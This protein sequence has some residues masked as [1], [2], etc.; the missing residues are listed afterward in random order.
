LTASAVAATFAA[1]GSNATIA[2]GLSHALVTSLAWLLVSHAYSTAN[3][4]NGGSVIYA[5]NGS[6]SHPSSGSGGGEG[7]VV[8]VVIRDVAVAGAVCTA[9][10][11]IMLES[12]SFGGLAYWGLF[13]RVLGEQWQLWDGV[14]SVA[15]GAG[16]VGVH[17]V[18]SGV[19]LLLVS[20]QEDLCF[21]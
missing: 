17:M 21:C 1:L 14:L 4:S 15:Y 11:A 7:S 16:M 13:G 6:L 20:R 2:L 5:A 19:S 3:S 9:V 12:F 10:A 8:A 18:V